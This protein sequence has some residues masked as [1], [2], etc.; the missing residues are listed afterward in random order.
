MGTADSQHDRSDIYEE[1]LKDKFR[2]KEEGIGRRFFISKT[3]RF[4]WESVIKKLF[5]RGS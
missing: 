4:T 3:W 5:G 2:N 1:V